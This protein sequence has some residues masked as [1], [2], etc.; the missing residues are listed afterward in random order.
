MTSHADLAKEHMALSEKPLSLRRNSSSLSPLGISIAEL[1]SENAIVSALVNAT[2]PSP[3]FDSSRSS[4]GKRLAKTSEDRSAMNAYLIVPSIA[5]DVYVRGSSRR[6]FSSVGLGW[7]NIEIARHVTEPGGRPEVP[8]SHHILALASGSEAAYG[9]H[10]GRDG[11]LVP[12]AKLPGS[13]NVDPEGVLPAVYPS[14]QTELTIC[15][16]DPAFIEG[17]AREQEPRLA[18]RLRGQ[19]AFRDEPAA[20]LIRL[21][22]EEVKSGGMS[23]RLYIDHLTFALGLRVLTLESRVEKHPAPGNVLS[24]PRLK[25][26]VDLMETEL[27]TDIDLKRLADE[28]GYSRNHFLRMFRAATGNTP[29]QYLLHVR[30]KK[31]Q[32]MMKDKKVN[33]IDVALATGFSSHAQLSRVFMQVLGVTP[34]QY[35]RAIT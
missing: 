23:G 33:L 17:L 3:D 7:R 35:R 21:M 13:M 14:T 22:E 11:R 28:S 24:N 4:R 19:M 6:L 27:A 12:Y 34:S 9:E 25:R 32:A 1:P 26:V 10:P 5:P 31:A 18:A 8:T 16:L 30:V 15:A 29:H 20:G 2:I